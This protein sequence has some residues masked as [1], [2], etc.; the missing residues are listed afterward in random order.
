MSDTRIALYIGN[1]LYPS[2]GCDPSGT[3]KS[4]QQSPLTN[5]ILSLLN[6][7]AANPDQLVY[8][9]GRS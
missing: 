9:D 2:Q 5:S 6:Q 3:V 7:S 4:L 8:N 1:A